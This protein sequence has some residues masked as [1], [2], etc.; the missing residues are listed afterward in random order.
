MKEFPL[1]SWSKR[2][3]LCS[4]VS[5]RDKAVVRMNWNGSSVDVS[6]GLEQSIYYEATDEWRGRLWAHVRAK[7]GA[8]ELAMLILSISVT[9]SVNCLTVTSLITKSCHQ[10]W[11]IYSGLFYKVVQQ[12][13]WGLVVYFRVLLVAVNVCNSEKNIKIGQ[14]LPKLWSNDKGSSFLWLTVYIIILLYAIFAVFIYMLKHGD[15]HNT[16][17]KCSRSK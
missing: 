2:G 5:T 7:G 6:C 15:G 1:K 17:N 9:F 8:C 16:E 13:I 14:Y 12:Q 11:P 10:C 4:V 3:L